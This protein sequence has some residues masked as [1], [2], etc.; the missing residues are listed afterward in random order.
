M[1][2]LRLNGTAPG[3]DIR[4]RHPVSRGHVFNAGGIRL[5]I[6]ATTFKRLRV[7]PNHPLH[8][9]YIGMHTGRASRGS[10]AGPGRFSALAWRAGFS[11]KPAGLSRLSSAPAGFSETR[12][13][14]GLSRVFVGPGLDRG[15]WTIEC[16]CMKSRI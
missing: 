1:R 10:R 11:P 6:E 14:P 13:F 2:S 5:G 4:T 16:C 9:A 12:G 7:F 3:K 15:F 8:E